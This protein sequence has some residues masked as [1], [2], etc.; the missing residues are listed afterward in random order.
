VAAAAIAAVPAKAMPAKA[1]PAKAMPAKP[2]MSHKTVVPEAVTVEEP[3]MPHETEPVKTVVEEAVP[4]ATP[5]PETP[6]IVIISI[7]AIPVG[8]SGQG[9]NNADQ[10]RYGMAHHS[11][12]IHRSL[13]SLW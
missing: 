8:A 5:V 3:V 12:A 9:K 13:L 10:E 6:P 4:A 11:A 7:V 2:G 1:M